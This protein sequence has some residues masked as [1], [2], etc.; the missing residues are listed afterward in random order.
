MRLSM[1]LSLIFSISLVFYLAGYTPVGWQV[2]ALTDTGIY[3]IAPD[4]GLNT[5][6]QPSTED[7]NNNPN[8]VLLILFGT[9]MASVLLLSFVLG[10]S[11][12]YI[13]PAIILFGIL[14]FFVF[15]MGAILDLAMPD[16]LRV[17]IIFFYNFITVMAVITFIRGGN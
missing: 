14:N 4:G 17:S 10:F 7:V 9:I 8:S 1:Y 2:L 12:I 3:N 6:I 16:M 5:T 11:A 15:P 13:I